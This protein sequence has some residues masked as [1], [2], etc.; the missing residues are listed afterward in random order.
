MV[1]VNDYSSKPF[2]KIIESLAYIEMEDGEPEDGETFDIG[3]GLNC[4]LLPFR[5]VLPYFKNVTI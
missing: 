3:N 5:E 4:Q 2:Y 1:D